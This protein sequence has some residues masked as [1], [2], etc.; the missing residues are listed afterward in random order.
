MYCYEIVRIIWFALCFN[1]L[2]FHILQVVMG[3]ILNI[4]Y[5]CPHRVGDHVISS[6]IMSH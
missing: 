6:M 3:S 1:D 4:L 5:N 2:Y